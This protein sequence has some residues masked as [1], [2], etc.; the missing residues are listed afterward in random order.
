MKTTVG[1]SNRHVHLKEED[2][3]ILFG[4]NY[5]LTLKNK[6]NQPNQFAANETVTIV[7]P[8]GQM[9]NVRIIGPIR[10]YTQIEISASDSYKLGVNP[11][12]R[13]SGDLK[14][15]EPMTIIGPKGSVALEEG[16]II[17]DRHIHIT[18][19]QMELY[20]FNKDDKIAVSI[21]GD[22]AA[23]LKNISLKV[24]EQS[25]FELHLDTD[26][27]NANLIKNGDIVD[28]FVI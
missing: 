24:D 13:S 7:G 17:A 5:E 25:Y 14:G 6:L 10:K 26:D 16:C 22:K 28:I 15:S 4:D 1:I 3:K 8:K 27:A 21:N 19:K 18:P 23:F 11:P 2:F 9:D 12:V 20:G